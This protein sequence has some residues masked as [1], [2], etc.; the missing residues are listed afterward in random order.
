[1]KKDVKEY[2]KY[3]VELHE[4]IDEINNPDDKRQAR[5]LSP[6][7]AAD[8]QKTLKEFISK[9]GAVVTESFITDMCNINGGEYYG[10]G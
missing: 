3:I 10:I 8:L 6:E 5:K 9:T 1:M 7:S 4:G 2:L